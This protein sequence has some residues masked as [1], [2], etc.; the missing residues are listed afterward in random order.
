MMTVDAVKIAWGWAGIRPDEIVGEN[1]FGNLMIRD[2]EKQYWRLCPEDL[3]CRVVA[4]NREELDVLS[5]CP[6]FLADW[7]MIRLVEEATSKN[8]PLREGMKYCLK[9]PSVLGGEYGG[10]NV[11]MVPLIE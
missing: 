9:I 10:E 7:L 6:E 2:E 5:T 4:K 8:G 3:Y 11:A 1:D